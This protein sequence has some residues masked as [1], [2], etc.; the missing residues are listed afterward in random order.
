MQRT[1]ETR[2]MS[3]YETCAFK[4]RLDA[5]VCN[6]KQYCNNDKCRYEWKELIDNGRRDYGFI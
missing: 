1:N 5:S 4:Y 6:D 3:W 2:H